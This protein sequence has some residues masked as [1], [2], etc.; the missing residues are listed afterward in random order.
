[1]YGLV[2]EMKRNTNVLARLKEKFCKAEELF[3]KKFMSFSRK[4]FLDALLAQM[5]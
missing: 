4:K 2:C 1:M 3:E 5:R